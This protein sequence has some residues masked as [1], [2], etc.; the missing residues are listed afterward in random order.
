VRW[1]ARWRWRLA[2]L[3]P[4]AF[5]AVALLVAAAFGALPSAGDY[6][7]MSGVPAGIGLVLV[8]LAINGLGEETGWRGFAQR[9][10]E[11]VGPPR[12]TAAV[13]VGWAGW[14]APLFAVMASYRDF[15]IP[16][17]LGFLVG[18]GA[19][20]VVLTS[21]FNASRG[22]SSPSRSGTRSTTSRSRPRPARA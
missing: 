17:A 8:A 14:H 11:R 10:Q 21:I 19:G 15:G 4:L 7:R 16:L 3:S 13:A 5:L 6:A 20:A 2:A 22:A 1:P 9:L 12:A 18:L